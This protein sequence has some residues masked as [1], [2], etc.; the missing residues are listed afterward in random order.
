[1]TVPFRKP[2]AVLTA[3]AVLAGVGA[4]LLVAAA[5]PCFQSSSDANAAARD[6]QERAN[7]TFNVL[8]CQA[9]SCFGL[10]SFTTRELADASATI[11]C[12][13]RFF[14]APDRCVDDYFKDRLGWNV[15]R[16]GQNTFAAAIDATGYVL[17]APLSPALGWNAVGPAAAGALAG[18]SLVLVP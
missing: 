12:S 2:I 4:T 6:C 13:K 16:L 18:T 7:R 11:D 5:Q 15:D 10:W 3:L 14:T 9:G 8:V 17:P 1:M